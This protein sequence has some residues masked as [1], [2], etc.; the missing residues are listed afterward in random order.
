MKS[1]FFALFSV[2]VLS[3]VGFAQTPAAAQARVSGAITS[4]NPS[5]NLV[6]VKSTTGETMDLAVTPQSHILHLPLGETDAKKAEKLAIADL[7]AGEEF[8]ASYQLS[9]DQKT[10]ELRTLYV[11]TKADLAEMAKKDDEDW[12]KR[13]TTG[14]LASVDAPS[15]TFTIKAGSREIKVNPAEKIEYLRYSPDSAKSSD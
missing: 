3:N 12:R 8:V 14:N 15:K 5:S 9:A 10:K 7:A 11:R 6:T 13:G 1:A 2:A 4:V